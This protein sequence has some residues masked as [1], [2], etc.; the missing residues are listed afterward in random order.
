MAMSG[1]E[2]ELGGA[3]AADA[4][5]AQLSADMTTVIQGFV[6]QPDFGRFGARVPAEDEPSMGGLVFGN[7]MVVALGAEGAVVA[8][9]QLKAGTSDSAASRKDGG[10]A[11]SASFTVSGSAE[12]AQLDSSVEST[13]AGVTG[14]LKTGIIIAPCP[15]PSGQFTATT[16]MSAS[17]SKAGG[18]TG[19][20]MTVDVTVT[21]QVDDDARVASVDVVTRIQSGQFESRKGQFV[22]ISLSLSE[23]AGVI[24]GDGRLNR[25]GG[26][27]TDGFIDDQA[28][29]GAVLQALAQKR[30]V[31]AVQKGWES[32]RCVVLT[33]ETVPAKRTGLPPTS[34]VT[35]AAAPRSTVDGTAVGG[36]V[37]ATLSGDGS[38]D[39]SGSKVPADA[40][41][42][43][44]APAEMDRIGVVSLEARSKRGVAKADVTLDTK[45]GGYSVDQPYGASWGR[46][47]GVICSLDKP[48]T[49]QEEAPSVQMAGAFAF[50]PK[51]DGRGTWAYKGSAMGGLSTIRGRGRYT[52]DESAEAGPRL[53]IG[54][55]RWTQKTA[56]GTFATPSSPAET[57]ALT[58]AQGGCD[59]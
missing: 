55:G 43:Y 23:R 49:L 54:P 38:L 8:T 42:A 18:T 14:K 52:S 27:V 59:G 5:L 13:T 44:T 25:S 33:P 16:T 45:A 26:A 17:V 11:G 12:K 37:T 34:T 51:G 28:R 4:A 9:N 50:T 35:I 41:F 3:A 48:F 58:P 30:L 10:D 40:T 22:D 39:P 7:I 21:G 29:L 46:I 53:T 36:T 6:S 1:L 57:L 15:D 47:F 32:G 20:T 24:T 19:S 2:A 56:L 31:E